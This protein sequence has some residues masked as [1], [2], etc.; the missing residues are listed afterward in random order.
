MLDFFVS[1]ETGPVF[2]G[3]TDQPE[4]IGQDGDEVIVTNNF[5]AE[6]SFFERNGSVTLPAS[7]VPEPGS[8]ILL[9]ISFA[10]YMAS[11]VRRRLKG[12]GKEPA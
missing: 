7:A 8:G 6:V 2:V 12:R 4:L 10:G 9:G 3:D 11:Q 5:A 1:T